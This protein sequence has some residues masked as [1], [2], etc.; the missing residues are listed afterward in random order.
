M[1]LSE[2]ESRCPSCGARI[3]LWG[4]TS[5]SGLQCYECGVRLRVS[6]AYVRAHVLISYLIAAIIVWLAGV[7]GIVRV[8]V[9]FLVTTCVVL[10]VVAHVALRLLPPTLTEAKS[11]HIT[12]LGLDR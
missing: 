8:C 7:R 4:A 10:V 12:T 1:R 6:P 3:F 2:V 11:D 9:S 5:S